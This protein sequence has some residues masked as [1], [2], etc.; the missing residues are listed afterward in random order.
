MCICLE[1]CEME[2]WRMTYYSFP[3]SKFEK[4]KIYEYNIIDN[5]LN[6]VNSKMY[7]PIYMFGKTGSDSKNLFMDLEK[8]REDRLKEI[9][10]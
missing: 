6:I 10:E 7:V 9:L 4:N 1:D 3:L 5:I 2:T 8:Y